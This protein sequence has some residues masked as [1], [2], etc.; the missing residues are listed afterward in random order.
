M[1]S[2]VNI[3]EEKEKLSETESSTAV[4]SKVSL[5]VPN[6]PPVTC[7]R[8]ETVPTHKDSS[9]IFNQLATSALMADSTW[10]KLLTVESTLK[11]LIETESF[12][13]QEALQVSLDQHYSYLVA[14]LVFV[15]LVFLLLLISV[16]LVVSAVLLAKNALI[17]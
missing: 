13:T 2:V 10:K 6:L 14:I 3:G 1:G 15:V 8:S 17:S 7:P 16:L 4:D 12:K 5:P 11:S 9:A